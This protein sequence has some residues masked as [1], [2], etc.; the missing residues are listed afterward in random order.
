MLAYK[1][2]L[3]TVSLSTDFLM[4]SALQPYGVFWLFGVITFAGFVYHLILMKETKHLTD[5]EKKCLYA[6]HTVD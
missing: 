4:D 1:A 5:K 3:L 2:A 6:R